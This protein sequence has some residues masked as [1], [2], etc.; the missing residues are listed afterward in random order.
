M[1]LISQVIKPIVQTVFYTQEVQTALTG[2]NIADRIRKGK[3][4]L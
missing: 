1:G 3:G 2:I 4:L